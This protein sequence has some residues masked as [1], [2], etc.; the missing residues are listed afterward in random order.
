MPISPDAAKLRARIAGKK[1][2]N[3][4]ADVTEERRELKALTL[5]EHI[6]RVISTAPVPTPEQLSR[7]RALLPPVE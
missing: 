2:H 5:E 4:D 3:P 6:Q 7:L 1:S